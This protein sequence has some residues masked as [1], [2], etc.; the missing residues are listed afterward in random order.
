MRWGRDKAAAG[1]GESLRGQVAP[2][3]PHGGPDSLSASA[4][5]RLSVHATAPDLCIVT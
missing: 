2:T 4:G 1:Y 3:Q 5:I